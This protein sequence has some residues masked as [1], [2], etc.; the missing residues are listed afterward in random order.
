M[1]SL[2]QEPEEIGRRGRA[3]YEAQ[4]RPLMEPSHTGEYLLPDVDTGDY[5][6]GPDRFELLDRAKARRS[7]APR[8]MLRIGYP[9]AVSFAGCELS[10]G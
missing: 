7:E 4:L 6:V 3:I 8:L 1:N 5:E 10:R 9:A 2:L